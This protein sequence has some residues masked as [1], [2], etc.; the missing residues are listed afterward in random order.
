MR[1]WLPES[2]SRF[3]NPNGP[4]SVYSMVPVPSFLP[5]FNKPLLNSCGVPTPSGAREPQEGQDP[6]PVLGDCPVGGGDDL[7]A[8]RWVLRGPVTVGTA[9]VQGW[10]SRRGHVPAEF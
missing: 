2:G 1:L 4:P 8:V 10:L 7:P 5:S 6:V 3:P 9:G